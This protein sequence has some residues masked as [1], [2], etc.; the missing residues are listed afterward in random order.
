MLCAL[1]A[2]AA[3]AQTPVAPADVPP[4]PPLVVGSATPGPAAEQLIVTDTKIGTGKEATTGATVYM[5]YSGWLYRPL[6]KAMHGKL[7]DSSIP[8]GEP[9][10]FVLGAGRVIK[11][12]DQGIQGMKVGGKRTLIIPSELAYGSRPT[13]G[14]GIPPNSALIFDVELVDVK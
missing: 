7:F 14:S 3:Q 4:P 6:A 11:G 8:R 5:H 10:D 13:P 12:W 2:S 9:L 1:A